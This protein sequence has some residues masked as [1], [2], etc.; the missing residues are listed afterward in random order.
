M[1]DTFN[2]NTTPNILNPSP[3]AD[4]PIEDNPA[5]NTK[6]IKFNINK[7]SVSTTSHGSNAN[8]QFVETSFDTPRLQEQ[9]HQL[10][11]SAGDT[12]NLQESLAY[13]QGFG[14]LAMKS[15]G[16][17]VTDTAGSIVEAT[18]TLGNVDKV[19]TLFS[20]DS[21][22]QREAFSNDNFLEKLGKGINEWGQEVMPI[23]QTAAANEGFAPT[24]KSWWFG[25]VVPGLAS[26]VGI[27]VPSMAVTEGL[28]IAGKAIS[29]LSLLSKLEGSASGADLL[30]N[31]GGAF[32][33]TAG[34]AIAGAITGRMIDSG[35]SASQTYNQEY[36]KYINQGFNDKEAGQYAATA[37]TYAYRTSYANLMFDTLEWYTMLKAIGRTNISQEAFDKLSNKLPS[38]ALNEVKASHNI[39][40]ESFGKDLA[41]TMFSEAADEVAMSGFQNLGV[42]KGEK[43][44]YGESQ[45]PILQRSMLDDALL[46]ALGGGLMMGSFRYL[47]RKSEQA[48]NE[49]YDNYAKSIID[50]TN[51][52]KS[53]ITQLAQ[54]NNLGSEPIA[55][56]VMARTISEMA[57]RA[58]REG[59][60][61]VDQT[62]LNSMANDNLANKTP[63]EQ[64]AHL[65]D[66]FDATTQL[67]SKW[68]SEIYKNTISNIE[69]HL[70]DKTRRDGVISDLSTEYKTAIT[71]KDSDKAEFIKKNLSTLTDHIL[72]NRAVN[73]TLLDSYKKLDSE[74]P[75]EVLRLQNADIDN[76]IQSFQD[77][78]SDA[79]LTYTNAKIQL[80]NTENTLMP[81]TNEK[82]V[83]DA[84]L[85]KLALEKTEI[86]KNS[87]YTTEDKLNK[88]S[89]IQTR[90][91][92]LLNRTNELN[93]KIAEI[94]NN[95][96]DQGLEDT[97]NKF[98]KVL[99]KLGLND[100][101]TI[102]D[103]KALTPEVTNKIESEDLATVE[104]YLENKPTVDELYKL[105]DKK[106]LT[107]N[108]RSYIK[109]QLYSTTRAIKHS[110]SRILN[111]T[112]KSEKDLQD[113]ELQ[114][115][116]NKII[117]NTEN[118]EGLKQ[119]LQTANA[120][121]NSKIK[122]LADDINI[123][124]KAVIV[125]KKVEADRKAAEKTESSTNQSANTSN[126]VSKPSTI[127]TNVVP[128]VIKTLQDLILVLQNQI[129]TLRKRSNAKPLNLVAMY[130]RGNEQGIQPI[131]V[132]TPF[133]VPTSNTPISLTDLTTLKSKDSVKKLVDDINEK[134]LS[135]I[136]VVTIQG[137]PAYVK[138]NGK[139]NA[140]EHEVFVN[141]I[142]NQITDTY[143]RL[144]ALVNDPSPTNTV[145]VVDSRSIIDALTQLMDGLNNPY[146]STQGYIY[147]K[148]NR[149]N[150]TQTSEDALADSSL[151]PTGGLN[152]SE[153]GENDTIKKE[154]SAPDGIEP[155]DL[156]KLTPQEL[157]ASLANNTAAIDP[158]KNIKFAEPLVDEISTSSTDNCVNILSELYRR[159]YGN[160]YNNVEFKGVLNAIAILTDL[161]TAIKVMPDIAMTL[162]ILKTN[163]LGNLI[164]NPDDLKLLAI[165]DKFKFDKVGYVPDMNE[166][167][168]PVYVNGLT[169]TLHRL[170]ANYQ[171]EY[172]YDAGLF[173][174]THRFNQ[175]NIN[176]QLTILQDQA[177]IDWLNTVSNL[178][179]GDN[180]TFRLANESEIQSTSS[181]TGLAYK[182]Y[183][184]TDQYKP[185]FIMKGSKVIGEVP[186]E[187]M[188]ANGIYYSSIA[189]VGNNLV[190]TFKP[191]TAE[192]LTSVNVDLLIQN[193]EVLKALWK[194]QNLKST[195]VDNLH[196]SNPELY[197]YLLAQAS[198][199]LQ[200]KFDSADFKF[201]ANM[202]KEV[203]KPMFLGV[204][205]ELID[206]YEVTPSRLLD[207]LASFTTSKQEQFNT[208]QSLRK[209]VVVGKT[210]VAKISTNSKP[211]LI[212]DT[213]DRQGNVAKNDFIHNVL[214]PE[215]NQI[216]LAVRKPGEVAFK[217]YDAASGR[218]LTNEIDNYDKINES[219][220][221]ASIYMLIPKGN[222]KFTALRTSNYTFGKTIGNIGVDSKNDQIRKTVATD[223]FSLLTTHDQV[224]AED[225][226]YRLHKNII[227]NLKKESTN[228]Y[229]KYIVGNTANDNNS[230][231]FRRLD[232]SGNVSYTQIRC[233]FKNNMYQVTVTKGNNLSE[234]H[235]SIDTTTTSI[236]DNEAIVTEP[237]SLDT[238]GLNDLIYNELNGVMRNAPIEGNSEKGVKVEYPMGTENERDRFGKST[239]TGIIPNNDLL[240]YIISTGAI[241]TKLGVVKDNTGKIITNFNY[242]TTDSLL[243]PLV[244]PNI[245]F[246]VDN[247]NQ[248]ALT[249]KEGLVSSFSTIEG[250]RALPEFEP[251]NELFSELKPTI[252]IKNELSNTNPNAAAAFD[253]NT[254]VIEVYKPTLLKFVSNTNRV[255]LIAHEMLH[256]ALRNTPLGIESVAAQ[257]LLAFKSSLI[258]YIGSVDTII[259]TANKDIVIAKEP[260]DPN[261][262]AEQFK[263]INIIKEYL[264]KAKTNETLEELIT[265]GL[266]NPSITNALLSIETGE[267]IN[268]IPVT[269]LDKFVNAI[270]EILGIDSAKVGNTKFTELHNIVSNLLL[271]STVKPVES[272]VSGIVNLESTT[273]NLN[274]ESDISG[275]N[276]PT[277]ED[278]G[279]LFSEYS[280][281]LDNDNLPIC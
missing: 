95:N 46:G 217:L 39:L 70:N 205:G 222:G 184:N 33:S 235:N 11:S 26:A 88:L 154:E 233:K 226:V 267:T 128:K 103:F 175:I 9:T 65:D 19:A 24:D 221:F 94:T 201:T 62:M 182:P 15:L 224:Y 171:K 4:Q 93:T 14:E 196:R 30:A 124:L 18:G 22:L 281:I 269:L 141:E 174:Y 112:Y 158:T 242:G 71:N 61:K 135:K 147:N 37:A 20:G 36:N 47:G 119:L 238:T 86:D 120:S 231:V 164:K 66:N 68:A 144:V 155:I 142:Y 137:Y 44:A 40:S 177:Q 31:I 208:I 127:P 277:N 52:L 209:Q 122:A 84:E 241:V 85:S 99:N 190:S 89:T 236:F 268:N 76:N 90:T 116:Q 192:P 252:E 165:R 187:Q 110:T 100:K 98:D 96:K 138:L 151:I 262:S 232:A 186:F 10:I 117:A 45:T 166:I 161:D 1:A 173:V 58:Y 16:H 64:Q 211:S 67:N 78:I 256:Y 7:A 219:G 237:M 257:A 92:A 185:I 264:N 216:R 275:E 199:N 108:E 49:H 27:M 253:P 29:K 51:D 229:F 265:Y 130:A 152:E 72:L 101:S 249:K 228:V 239:N 270:L 12:T 146:T 59:L 156:T 204:S 202:L 35:M 251:Y 247:S 245:S 23:T 102:N 97:I 53:V 180:I 273:T 131:K 111:D 6:P 87:K 212:F 195:D 3:V 162:N 121:T 79:A 56:T 77:N 126:P 25:K 50:R 223:I 21:A 107:Q 140:K 218:V 250:I 170:F 133:K 118:E 134:I 2:I 54:A 203:L 274:T 234:N 206:S 261:I 178:K 169:S 149:I 28:G 254:N 41:T 272:T 279:E 60:H 220:D 160:K 198:Y 246:K 136:G 69:L 32:Q 263:N 55:K 258:D 145:N 159:A 227:T 225:A 266:T 104:N 244:K 114:Q 105:Q 113:S 83:L 214:K 172:K 75:L 200:F 153:V 189:E 278:F 74:L 150:L 17:I 132:T 248:Q 167:S 280:R 181:V 42:R 73:K 260:S 91:K 57:T 259:Y 63:E 194:S 168:E 109:Q 139:L 5:I 43:Q 115:F 215:G 271:N 163:V 34:K 123:K 81:L 148:G 8:R 143:N 176:G 106:A 157:L 125:A 48:Q 240:D 183:A 193:Q 210:M 243:Q 276:I 80:K 82:N 230:I 129:N 188:V 213:L 13:N 207:N 191:W 179:L 197:N 255:S 38:T